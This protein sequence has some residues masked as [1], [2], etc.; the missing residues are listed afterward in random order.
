MQICSDMMNTRENGSM[1]SN[2]DRSKMVAELNEE[3]KNN[4]R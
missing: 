2:A 3:L 4:Q 1:I